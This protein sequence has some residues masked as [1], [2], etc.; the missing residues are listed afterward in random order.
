[1]EKTIYSK[2]YY[3]LIKKLRE[4]RLEAG[5][6]QQQVAKTLKV[7]QNFISKI[8]TGVRRIDFVELE[9]FAKIYKKDISFFK[10]M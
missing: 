4:A 3:T 5:L 9:Q 10:T 1:M 8:E 6:S 2:R 7:N